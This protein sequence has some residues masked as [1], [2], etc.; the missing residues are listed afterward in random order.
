MFGRA[1]LLDSSPFS[2]LLKGLMQNTVRWRFDRFY[3]EFFFTFTDKNSA[4]LTFN[5]YFNIK[6]LS[7]RKISLGERF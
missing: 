6:N 1:L 3:V 2:A 5:V 4:N 7:F